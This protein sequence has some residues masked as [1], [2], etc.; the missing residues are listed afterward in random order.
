MSIRLVSWQHA[1][2][3]LRLRATAGLR[4][5][6]PASRPF[7]VAPIPEAGF[8]VALCDATGSWTDLPDAVTVCA[9]T[10]VEAMAMSEGDPASRLGEAL[11]SADLAMCHAVPRDRNDW[12]DA[13]S[14]SASL[15]F[16]QGLDAW[17]A[18]VGAVPLLVSRKGRAETKT[19]TQRLRLG[20]H[21]PSQPRS[22]RPEVAG[23]FRLATGDRIVLSYEN[24]LDLDERLPELVDG[25][26]AE[27]G[28]EALL[29]RCHYA[30]PGAEM[31]AVVIAVDEQVRLR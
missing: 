15:L 3:G 8:A 31:A 10:M 30:Y 5:A 19:R 14:C 17:V 2:L 7:A 18:W 6:P 11:R 16:V 22:V 29:E 27:A 24:F 13:P 20:G 23:P 1:T 4:D 21:G 28:V 9:D 26:D 25:I 12:R